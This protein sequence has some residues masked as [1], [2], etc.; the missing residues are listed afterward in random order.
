M[1]EAGP[2]DRAGLSLW[3]RSRVG[4]AF[5]R[6]GKPAAGT[7]MSPVS[8]RGAA[9]TGLQ[10]LGP[11]PVRRDGSSRRREDPSVARGDR[12][13]AGFSAAL[14]QD[15]IG[16]GSSGNGKKDRGVHGPVGDP[17]SSSP[18]RWTSCSRCGEFI[19]SAAPT[20]R[21]PA[22][23]PRTG[24]G[25]ESH[26]QFPTSVLPYSR[27]FVPPVLQFLGAESREKRLAMD[28]ATSSGLRRPC[29]LLR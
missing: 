10:P 3:R 11:G 23:R 15:D 13:E 1:K 18:R 24:K 19:R 17:T 4:L 25:A 5:S 28:S 9:R 26:P 2:E 22:P 7:A 14:P 12:G 16:C 8:R 6:A 20:G 29:F 27:T 21:K